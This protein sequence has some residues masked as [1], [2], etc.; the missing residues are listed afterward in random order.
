MLENM[1]NKP[2]FNALTKKRPDAPH[3][4]SGRTSQKNVPWLQKGK[5][6]DKSKN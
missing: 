1:A 4:G 3:R 2:T 5:L 6:V